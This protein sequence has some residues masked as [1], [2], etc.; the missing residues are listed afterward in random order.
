MRVVGQRSAFG[1]QET[2][3]HSEV[4]QERPTGFKSNNQI[5]SAPLN[6]RN[7]FAFQRGRH[8]PRLERTGQSGIVDLDAHE[9]TT[10]QRRSETGPHRLY[11]R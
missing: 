6:G 5:L 9:A 10:S 1:V 3:R 11:F 8:G 2:S 7:G 4:N